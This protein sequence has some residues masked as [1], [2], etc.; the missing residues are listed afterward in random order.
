MTAAA[1]RRVALAVAL[2][3]ATTTTAWS[4]E[5]ER[6]ASTSACVACHGRPDFFEGDDLAIVERFAA[7]VH[8]EVGLSCEDCHGGNPD[9]DPDDLSAAMDEAFVPNPFRGT[10][11]RVDLPRFCGR[12]HSD[13]SYMKRFAPA[14]RID[15][16]AEY[17]T[18]H[19]GQ[20]LARG[21]DAVATCVDCHGVHGIRRVASPD[22]P[23]YPSRVA[24]TCGGCHGNP[25][26]MA[27]RTRPDGRPLPVDQL[28]RWR[29]SVH[30]HAL[31]AKGDLS[32]PTCNDCHGNHG[33]T[34]PGVGSIA[35]VCG[36]CHGREARLFQASSKREGFLEHDDFVAAAGDEGCASCHSPPEPQA[37]HPALTAFAD[38]A[39]CHGNHSVMRPTLAMLA[40]LPA[41]PCAFCHEG[42]GPL[43]EAVPEPAGVQRRYEQV[44]GSLL[45]E[46]AA[47]GVEGQALF[48]WLVDQ[49]TALPFH[50]HEDAS[51][52][53]LRPEF[54]TLFDKFR[55]G[56]ST[57]T[58]LDPATGTEVAQRVVRCDDCHAA[59]P[60]LADGPVGLDTARAFVERIREVTAATA[61]AE[62][63]LLAARRGGVDTRTAQAELAQAVDAQIG[64]EVL[65]HG[66]SAAEGGD[67]AKKAVEGV[68]HARLALEA[69]Q[70]ALGELESRRRGLGVALAIIAVL[71]V[72]LAA[73]IRRLSRRA[74]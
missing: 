22:S 34:P 62:R 12:C 43:A 57:F 18:S 21:D 48:D 66:F 25:R 73:K 31:L 74:D 36:G 29:Q 56:K 3:A 65:V 30:A 69:G 16:E 52:R 71:L 6:A 32:A 38:C 53:V 55:I 14:T 37:E 41:I 23:V 10:P 64:L 72:A 39:T 54:G 27:G 24:E 47:A 7:D 46:A 51:G 63:V 19:H 20:A 45:A 8:A 26:R 70:A 50:V 4:E 49:A 15:Q 40:P 59:E 17:A 2:L 42:G 58:L 1:R 60:L 9:A 28:A 5:L 33:A 35:N 67:F 61:R 44:K 13:A 68:D 11:Q